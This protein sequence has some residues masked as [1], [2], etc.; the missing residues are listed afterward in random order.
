MINDLKT[1]AIVDPENAGGLMAYYRE[2]ILQMEEERK[3]LIIELGNMKGDLTES[4]N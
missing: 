3:Q 4:H 2:K 1:L